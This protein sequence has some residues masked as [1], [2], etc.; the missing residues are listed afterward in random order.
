MVSQLKI[1]LVCLELRDKA[2][3]SSSEMAHL[4]ETR[5]CSHSKATLAP[6]DK[7]I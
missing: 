2:E 1:V 6:E 7:L 5:S 3:E 4:A